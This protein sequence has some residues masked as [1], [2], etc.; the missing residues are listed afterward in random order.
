MRWSPHPVSLRQL[1][2]LAA[3]A[4]TRSFHRAAERCHVS[5]PALS[6]QVAEAERMLGMRIFERDR[7]R[8]L[9]TPAVSMSFL[10]ANRESIQS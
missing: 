9:V 1:Q 10:S 8:V 3:V 5:Q 4:D 2:Y 6:A 7:R